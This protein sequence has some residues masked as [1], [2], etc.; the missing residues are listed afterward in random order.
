VVVSSS[1]TEEMSTRRSDVDRA[2][3]VD[4]EDGQ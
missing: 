2:G 4:A 1:S 3:L